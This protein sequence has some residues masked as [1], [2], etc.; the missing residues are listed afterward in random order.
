MANSVA[1]AAWQSMEPAEAGFRPDLAARLEAGV[2]AGL[3]RDLHGVVAAR[4]GRIVLEQYFPGRDEAWGQDLGT[5]AFGPATLH[6]LRSVTKSLVGLLYGIALARGLVPPPEAPLY[7]QFPAYADLLAAD[8][9]RAAITVGH[10]LTM[11][12]GTAWDELSVPYTDP[13]NS[14]IAMELAPD[15]LRFVLDR[16][17]VQAPGQ[18]WSYSG[19]AVA[20]L[21]ALIARGSG[22]TL[23]E[24]AAE[25]L[26]RPLGIG[27][28][29]WARG[30]DGV[31]S[32]ASGARLRPRDLLRIGQAVLE[33]GALDG[34]QVVPKAWLAATFTPVVPAEEGIEY[35]RL[36]YL[37]KMEAPALGRSVRWAAGFGNG[38]QRLW[39]VPELGLTVASVSGAYNRP[40]AWVTPVRVFREIVLA[41]VIRA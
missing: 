28:T 24:F 19:G 10:V 15:R 20:L 27:T 22:T 16:A 6:D 12:M 4:H 29:G 37:G 41:N 3:L 33:D 38:G 25:A 7:A 35:G 5:V 26:F 32:A 2:R 11:T 36:W 21:G 39:V 9:R 1:A 14:E 30:S 8:P 40:D 31:A 34:Q 17:V 18:R 13:A 23:E